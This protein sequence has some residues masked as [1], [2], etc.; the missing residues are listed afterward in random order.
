M[1]TDNDVKDYTIGNYK[2]VLSNYKDIYDQE[3]LFIKIKKT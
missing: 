2:T 1:K 3:C